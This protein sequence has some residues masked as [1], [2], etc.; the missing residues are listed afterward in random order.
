LKEIFFQGR[1]DLWKDD[2]TGFVKL[3]RSGPD[4][5]SRV[6]CSGRNPIFGKTLVVSIYGAPPYVT[7]DPAAK[8]VGGIDL[9]LVSFGSGKLGY[10]L[11]NLSTVFDFKRFI[12]VNSN[13]YLFQDK[14][15][16]SNFLV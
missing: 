5:F 1:V 10:F 6:C 4:Y 13:S 8:K 14:I 16:E 9:D 12:V 3:S 2:G 11:H 7:V 15:M